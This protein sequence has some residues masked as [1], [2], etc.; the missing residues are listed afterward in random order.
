[1]PRKKTLAFE[2]SLDELESL[3]KSMDSGE[4]SLEDSLQAFEKGIG[5]I[6]DCQQALQNAEQKVQKL[7][8]TQD[9]LDVV[10]LDLDSAE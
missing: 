6:R 2:A 8:E 5:L 1:M 7:I 9:G 10:D 4:L 3:V